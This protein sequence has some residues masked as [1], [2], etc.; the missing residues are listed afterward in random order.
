LRHGF[1]GSNPDCDAAGKGHVTVIAS[2]TVGVMGSGSEAHEALARPVGELLARLEVNLLTG[3]GRGVMT[4]VSRA[5]VEARQ[6]RGV[7]IGIVPC[8]SLEIRHRPRSGSPNPYVEL[9]I[10]TH[11]PASGNEGRDDLSR[12]HINILTSD[13]VIALP[14][15]EGTASEVDLAIAYHK[16]IIAFAA[17]ARQLMNFSSGV[18]R[19]SDIDDVAAFLLRHLGSRPENQA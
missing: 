4:S 10:H 13:A 11:L 3:A 9:P 19:A 17:D 6:G 1:T 5:Y 15:S 8:E 18:E 14:G 12:N 7:S 16:P 2:Q